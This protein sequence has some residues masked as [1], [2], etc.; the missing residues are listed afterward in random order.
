MGKGVIPEHVMKILKLDDIP[1]CRAY[2]RVMTDYLFDLSF[3]LKGKGY[4]SVR[5]AFGYGFLGFQP[6]M[7]YDF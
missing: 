5:M 1:A 6:S 3:A 7:W 4:T 2:L